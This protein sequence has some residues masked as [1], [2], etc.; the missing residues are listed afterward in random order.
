M[1]RKE[2]VKGIEEVDKLRLQEIQT[3]LIDTHKYRVSEE[4]SAEGR[5]RCLK[6]PFWHATRLKDTARWTV[7]S[8]LS[9]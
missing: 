8:L 5:S 6:I 1:V 4:R 3:S 9:A 2:E 7:D